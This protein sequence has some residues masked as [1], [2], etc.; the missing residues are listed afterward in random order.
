[1]IR[2][3]HTKLLHTKLDTKLIGRRPI[4]GT[5]PSSMNVYRGVIAIAMLGSAPL[6][7]TVSDASIMNLVPSMD[8]TDRVLIS[9][10]RV[11][12]KNMCVCDL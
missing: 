12:K 1:M 11:S 10:S 3:K 7:M 2:D 5:L 8:L 4:P 9:K 6:A